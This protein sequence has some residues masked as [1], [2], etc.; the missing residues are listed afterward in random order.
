MGARV[1]CTANCAK[2]AVHNSVEKVSLETLGLLPERFL[3]SLPSDARAIFSLPLEAD[4]AGQSKL[5]VSG[6]LSQTV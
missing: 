6:T 1:F 5:L 2:V 3:A 4:F